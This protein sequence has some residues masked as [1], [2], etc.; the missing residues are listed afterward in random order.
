MAG[1]AEPLFHTLAAIFYFSE[2]GVMI[3]RALF[4]LPPGDE[5]FRRF[6]SAALAA[7]VFALDVA[8]D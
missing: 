2:G 6:F 3:G 8:L 1:E 4:P 5:V 7:L